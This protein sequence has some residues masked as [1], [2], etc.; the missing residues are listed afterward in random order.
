MTTQILTV[1]LTQKRNSSVPIDFM[2][3]GTIIST[4][5]G[6]DPEKILFLYNGIEGPTYLIDDL[7]I[8]SRSILDIER[9]IR[10]RYSDDFFNFNRVYIRFYPIL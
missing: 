5:S 9:I 1:E 10:S 3:L 2:D 7:P 4:S 6:I 8:S